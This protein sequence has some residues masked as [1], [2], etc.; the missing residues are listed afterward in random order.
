MAPVTFVLSLPAKSTKF[1]LL[2]F[3]EKFYPLLSL[4]EVICS[5]VMINMAWLLLEI[6]FIAVLEVALF[7]EPFSNKV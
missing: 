3:V 5:T 4:F 2:I 1:N 6:S 7:S